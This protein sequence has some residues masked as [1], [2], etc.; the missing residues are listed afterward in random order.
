VKKMLYERVLA[1]IESAR[2]A[3]VLT[4]TGQPN[5]LT[6]E[7]PRDA[8]H[9]DWATNAALVL[10]KPERKAPRDLA[11]IIIDHLDDPEGFIEKTDIAGPGF[12]NFTLSAKWWHRVVKNILAQGQSYGRVDIGE[13]KKVQVEFVSANPTGPLHVGHGRGAA[14][15]DALAS[16]LDAA[17]FDVE[18]EYYINDAGRQMHTLGRS[19]WYRYLELNG[20]SV[21]F[22]DDHYQG[23]YIR[24]L[25]Q[26]LKD[27]HGDRFVEMTDH[28]AVAEIY[29]W[30]AEQ[31]GNGI[32]DDLAAFGVE[33]NVWFSEKSL[34]NNGLLKATL[35]DM[36]ERGHIYDKDGAVWFATEKLKDDKDR[37]LIKSSGDHTYFASDIAYHRDK[38][39][40]G[41]DTVIDIWGA[42]HHGYVGRMKAAVEALGY[43]RDQL[44]VLLVQLVNLLRGGTPVAMST[45]AGQF[46]TLK[47]VVDEVGVDAAR[48]LFLTRSSD[49]PLDFDLELAKT[50]T[51]DNPVYYV[52]YAHARITSVFKKAEA[53]GFT[54]VDPESADL[55]LLVEEEE[56]GL[57]KFL[58]GFPQ[59]VEG[60][61]LAR[62]PHRLTHYLTELA[63]KF[64]P[65]YNRHKFVS[66][67]KALSRSRLVL[68]QAVRQIVANGLGLLGV[69]APDSM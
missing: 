59:L 13:N 44:Q 22:P 46:V 52:Q 41:F 60:A 28:D 68:A 57:M 6:V 65:Y 26:E 11:Q 62:E 54:E 61:A 5:G 12:I 19:V 48:F 20:K 8:T 39:K 42:D 27:K 55:T 69:S 56:L 66:E 29:P 64:H 16:L 32:R 50:Q 23:D 2:Q 49:S 7:V 36:R 45:R 15:G 33:Y 37:V 67:D 24:D 35:D 63:K 58:A 38:F 43:D 17:G 34:Y 40:R 30:A 51:K 53:E 25:A 18:R 10:A 21:D 4:G 14:V 31:I 47:E 9:G 3:G 1:S